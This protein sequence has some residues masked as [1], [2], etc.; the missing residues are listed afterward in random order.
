MGTFYLN[1]SDYEHAKEEF[2]EA[3]KL[4]PVHASANFGMARALQRMGDAD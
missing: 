4:N 2:A 3:L 1:L